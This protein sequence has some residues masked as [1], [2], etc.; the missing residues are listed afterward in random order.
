MEHPQL[1]RPAWETEGWQ[2]RALTW[3]ESALAQRS[4]RV[5]GPICQPHLRPWSMVL[6]VPT[7]SGPVYF[8]AVTGRLRHEAAIS[9]ALAAWQPQ[10]C[11]EVLAFDPTRGWLLLPDGGLRLREPLRASH[12][13]AGWERALAEYAALQVALIPRSD[14]LLA[15]GA[16]DRR[17]QRLATLIAEVL[18]DRPAL[19]IDRTDS[20]SSAQVR[21]LEQLAQPLAAIERLAAELESCGVPASLHH[22]D[23]HD[24]NVFVQ[25]EILRFFD[26]GDCSLAHP[27]FSLRTALVSAENSFGLAEDAP[28]LDRLRDAYLEPWTALAPA[29]QVRAAFELARKLWSL[30][31]ALGWYTSLRDLAPAQRGDEAY[32]VPALLEEFLLDQGDRPG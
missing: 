11:L 24:G 7:P 29:G 16:P 14:E 9:A 13:L 23:L 1:T 18:A 4:S 31:S 25:G 21:R 2:E 5:S 28:E 22:G 32:A 12:D 6:Q 8:K 3:I 20:L 15:L 26:W 19:L 10:A 27:F 30:P 17:P